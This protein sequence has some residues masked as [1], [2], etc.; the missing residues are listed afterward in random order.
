MK[1]R[2]FT[3]LL[4]L[5]MLVL[6]LPAMRAQETDAS[7]PAADTAA[8][9]SAAA[10]APAPA[11]DNTTTAAATVVVAEQ[12]PPA[13]VPELTQQSTME[14]GLK[15]TTDV[16]L[17]RIGD[18]A[19]GR[20]IASFLILLVAVVLRKFVITVIFAFLHRL[21]KWTSNR[22]G[23]RIVTA[24]KGPASAV[25]LVL[26]VFL[27]ITILELPP[28]IDRFVL[29]AFKAGILVVVFWGFMRAIDVVG[30]VLTEMAKEKELGIATFAPLLKKTARFF[31]III[32]VILIVQNLGY[33]VGSLLAGL[34][35][36]GLAVALAA[37][38]SLANFFGSVVVA[39][40]RPMRVGDF[41]KINNFT[42]T[43]EE[44]GLRSTRMRTR[45]KTLVTIPNKMMANEVIENFSAISRRRIEQTLGVTYETEPGQMEAILEDLRKLLKEDEGI[46]QSEQQIVRFNAF[47][48]S[49][50]DI[51]VVYYAKTNEFAAA[52]EVRERINLKMMRAVLAR[53]LSFAFPTQTLY[54]EGEIARKLAASRDT[55]AN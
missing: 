15:W 29:L 33:S 21:T 17:L 20:V 8:P 18:N 54:L 16:L 12:A 51:F 48:S 14:R 28:E 27:S 49:S 32:G 9:E 50:L 5:L 22:F 39:T 25:V 47:G 6:A 36:G 3:R 24:V 30:D 38:D 13:P 52:L 31:F 23:D 37:Q 42:G 55:P 11:A 41:V 4:V 43:I 2:L 46:D 26:G 1:P 10:A 45:E 40:D 44:V 19:A 34:G 35:I 53:G 7:K